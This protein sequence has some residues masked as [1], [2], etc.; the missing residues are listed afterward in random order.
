MTQETNTLMF[1]QLTKESIERENV[2]FQL[3]QSYRLIDSLA[4]IIEAEGQVDPQHVSAVIFAFSQQLEE[5]STIVA[6]QNEVTTEEY[7]SGMHT[8]QHFYE[9]QLRAMAEELVAQAK[10]G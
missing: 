4:E 10:A 1:P 5:M 6:V 3:A 7:E 9:H 2:V 8:L